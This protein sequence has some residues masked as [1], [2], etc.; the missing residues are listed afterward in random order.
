MSGAEQTSED[1]FQVMREAYDQ[2]LESWS[3]A[4]E[5]FLASQGAADA[6]REFMQRYIEAHAS[7]RSASQAAAESIHFPTTD[8]VA[9]L[10]ELVINVERKLEE[11]GDQARATDERLARIE[12]RL[13]ELVRARV[14]DDGPPAG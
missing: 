6:S 3:K 5:Q 1:P 4:T 13:G 2:A 7:L 11:V 8:D 12:T 10:A 9:R 14:G